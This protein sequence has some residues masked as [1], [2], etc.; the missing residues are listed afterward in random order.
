[1]R[2]WCAAKLENSGF[3]LWTMDFGLSL[4]CYASPHDTKV[5]YLL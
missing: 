2:Q 4:W 3:G 5:L 1:M